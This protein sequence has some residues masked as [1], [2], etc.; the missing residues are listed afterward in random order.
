M[1]LKDLKIEV[2]K[3]WKSVGNT[4]QFNVSNFAW[5]IY[6]IQIEISPDPCD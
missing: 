1:P 4:I 6:E 2:E 5:T 3:R